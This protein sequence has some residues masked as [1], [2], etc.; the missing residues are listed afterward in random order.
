MHAYSVSKTHRWIRL[1]LYE[2]MM[3]GVF[4]M[5]ALLAGIVFHDL[6]HARC[7]IVLR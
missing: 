1:V 4:V 5:S 3:T 6:P 2:R 7:P